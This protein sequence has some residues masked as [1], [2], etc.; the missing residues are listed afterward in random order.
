MPLPVY[1]LAMAVFA[2][3]TS[4]FMLAGLVPDIAS[5]LHVSLA[6]A[7]SLTSAFAV[8]MV[9]GAPIMAALSR[10]WPRRTS[11]TVFLAVFVAAHVLGARTDNFEL[12]LVTRIVAAL[13]NAGFLAV[14][15][16]AATAMV[17]P[18]R[19]ARV[20]AVLLGGTTVACVA[21]VPGG[22]LL[23]AG[24]GWRAAFW[25]V[26]VLC[27]P[28]I[29]GVLGGGLGGRL[30]GGLG[31]VLGGGATGRTDRRRP[32]GLRA[33]LAQLGRPGLLLVL[34]LGALV[35]GATFCTFSYL[36]PVV[37]DTARLGPL[38]VPVVLA[39]FGIG[40][41]AGVSIAGRLADRRPAAVLTLGGGL[42][43]AGWIAMALT[44]GWPAALVGLAFLQ[45]ALAFGVGSTLIARAL[46]L[47]PGAPTMAGSYAT[48]AF[49]VGAAAG[50]A[51][52]GL[53]L[54]TPLGLT[55]PSWASAVLVAAALLVHL[56]TGRAA[57]Y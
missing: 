50:P 42:L 40:S 25:A 4:E 56:A 26:A 38:W 11:L 45:G 27:L 16:T 29:A 23:E 55:G 36:A 43:L 41:F 37:T 19:K 47:A 5:E 12:L 2:M 28:A 51:I 33:E 34:T 44:A 21:G 52:G 46:Y 18:D 6:Q 57:A 32:P 30:G 14:A 39:A 22:A 9:L 13:M 15:V 53:A 17:A 10:S 49:N 48:A 7:G 54:A 20:L 8:G 3:G 31:G 35:N 24:F 1:L